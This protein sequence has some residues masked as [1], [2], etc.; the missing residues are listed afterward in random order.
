MFAPFNSKAIVLS[1]LLLSPV[2]CSANSYD[3]DEQ[4][5]RDAQKLVDQDQRER[6]AAKQRADDAERK[7]QDNSG[8]GGGGIFLI[9][10]GAA[11]GLWYFNK[12]S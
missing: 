10:G 7:N 8:G 1:L 6:D 11:F 3:E 12:K 2:V 9:L 4:L 5:R